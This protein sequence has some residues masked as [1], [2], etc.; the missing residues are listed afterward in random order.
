MP[1][2]FR[3]NAKKPKQNSGLATPKEEIYLLYV[4]DIINM[5]KSDSKGILTR[6]NFIMKHGRRFHLLYLTP[7]SQ[8]HNRNTEGDVDS[9][10]W[11]KKI[12]GS[13]P[14][15]ELEINEFVKN[16][17]N[18]GF[19]AVVKSCNSQYK[20]IYG[21]KNNPLYFTGS[22]VDNNE[23]KGYELTFEQNFADDTPVLF[24]QGNILI[25]EDALDPSSPEYS[26][27]FVKI[28][29]SN[30]NNK[31]KNNFLQKLGVEN[32]IKT[33]IDNIKVGGRNL[34]LKSETP[35]LSTYGG[36]S[37]ANTSN[38]TVEEWNT[39]KAMR[40]QVSGGTSSLKAVRALIVPENGTY[41]SVSFFV[42]NLS[43]NNLI[44]YS[45]LGGRQE[46]IAPNEAKRV[47]WESILG[48]GM[49]NLQI[50]VRSDN[51]DFALWRIKAEQ[52][53]KATD[54]TPA[55]EDFT[56]SNIPNVTGNNLYKTLVINP[57][58]GD[59]GYKNI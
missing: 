13:Y 53:T 59:I 31:N 14:G 26:S 56:F 17:I 47:V 39:S 28:D 20:K 4:E 6:G 36:S 45:N 42:K 50:Q 41:C 10:G 55:V 29:A 51:A 7:L 1:N 48:N 58:T 57:N 22:F 49:G 30:I 33:A 27:L 24:Y 46:T 37:I 8:S 23:S 44:L 3:L 32:L 18:Q 12:T 5:P 16:N 40:V 43:T 52:G 54:W 25:D 34:I 35:S 15:D 38:Y 11:K 9:R 2:L 21:S 19:V